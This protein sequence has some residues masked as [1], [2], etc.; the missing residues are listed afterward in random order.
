MDW[1]FYAVAL[2]VIL[3]L[4]A[5]AGCALHWAVKHGQTRALWRS[6]RSGFAPSAGEAEDSPLLPS[7]APGSSHPARQL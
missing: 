3:F 6:V 7:S 1:L 4:L 5:T 2:P